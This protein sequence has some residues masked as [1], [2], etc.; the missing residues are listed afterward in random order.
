[1]AAMCRELC[2]EARYGGIP[3]GIITPH[4]ENRFQWQPLKEG[5][6]EAG[7]RE[8]DRTEERRRLEWAAFG[9]ADAA[10]R[11]GRIG[12]TA[13]L[14]EVY[15]GPKPGLVDPFSNGAHTDMDLH[16]F[17]RSAAVLEPYFARMARAGLKNSGSVRQLFPVIRQIGVQAEEAMYQAT[18]GVNTHKGAVFT[19]GILCAAAGACQAMHGSISVSGL[20]EIE[21]RMVQET[22]LKEIFQLSGIPEGS[23]ISNGQRNYKRYGALG[24]RGE[25]AFGYPS[26]L[27][28]ALP[29][30]MKGW[31]EGKSWNRIKLQTLFTLMSHVEDGNVLSR[32]GSEGMK[33]VRQMADAF[34][35]QGGA[36]R[37]DALTRLMELDSYFI[38]KNYSN[39]GCADLLAATVFLALATE[40][41][42]KFYS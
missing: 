27:Q 32:T 8:I 5:Q 6:A 31:K 2:S 18:G 26:V 30:M 29:V 9:L 40:E 11:I 16:T 36:Y 23:F 20:I 3:C 7:L 19:I 42:L 10:A 37:R 41:N 17:E 33:E 28:W 12:K 35:R 25:A 14:E 39:G 4:S 38:R 22:L 21:Q 24:V 34:L 15:T 13:L 1:M